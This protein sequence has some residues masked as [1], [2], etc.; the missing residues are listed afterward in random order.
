MNNIINY[1]AQ[2]REGIRKNRI[3]Q[4]SPI[5][6]CNIV[7]YYLLLICCLGYGRN[8][9]AQG[10]IVYDDKGRRDPF[11][12]L[13]TPDGRLLNLEPA[14][15]GTKVALEGII[16][17]KNGQSYAIINGE[18]VGVGDYIL[19]YSVVNINKDM[20]ILMKNNEYM[21]YKLQKEEP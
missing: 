8:V 1:P 16:Y 7:V 15:A 11:V 19:G 9:F 3:P 4:R 12:S 2:Y 6:L 18:V 14:G 17:D 21:E 13:V 5:V 20:V 10:E